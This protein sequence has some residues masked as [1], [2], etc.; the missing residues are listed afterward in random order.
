MAKYKSTGY[1]F[2]SQ[3]V[4]DEE[5]NLQNMAIKLLK[6]LNKSGLIKATDLRE[7]IIQLGMSFIV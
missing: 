6:L 2:P 3:A 7:D 5:K 4:S 1:D